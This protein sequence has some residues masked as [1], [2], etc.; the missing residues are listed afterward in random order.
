[1]EILR[2]LWRRKLRSFLTII[3]IV[4]GILALT[5]MG[6]IAEHFNSLLD[7]GITYFST[8]IQVSDDKSQGSFGGG[9][10]EV[11]KAAQIEAVDGV[12]AASPSISVNAKPGDFGGGFGPGDTINNVD[13]NFTKYS[14]F[15]LEMDQGRMVDDSS[16]GE[17]TMGNVIA[18]EFKVKVGDYVELPKKPA[19]AKPDFINH[20]FQVVG[21]TKPTL[22]APD[23]F[24]T[25]SLHDAQM[26]FGESL[27]PAIRSQIDP[28]QLASGIVA[29]GKPGVNLDNLADKITNDVKGVKA[30][31]PSKIVD[32]FKSFGTTFT[33]ITTAA[34]LLA[35][36]I[37]GISVVNTMIMAVTERVREIG[38]KKAVGAHTFHVLREYL[39]EAVLIGFLG[40]AIGYLAGLG[41][42]SLLNTLGKGSNLELFLVTPT[43]TALAIGFAVAL[44]ALA[45]VIPALRAAR[46]DPVTA[47]RTTN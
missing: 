11:S 26:L 27:S 40:G 24:A 34:A 17:V 42:T 45:G 10:I 4:M 18:S 32:A 14:K 23:N 28:Y 5:T 22:T 20:R 43:L 13:P 35:L 8:S 19:D 12:A 7:G 15:K 31:R 39:A 21:I 36:V 25:V 37:G 30:I 16:R 6:A 9:L 33:L 44:G 3:G 41:L 47:L 38:L 29:Y 46:L 1:L 2:N